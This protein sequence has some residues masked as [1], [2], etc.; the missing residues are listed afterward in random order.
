MR[1]RTGGARAL[2][3][4]APDPAHQNSQRVLRNCT[5]RGRRGGPG[6]PGQAG[7]AMASPGRNHRPVNDLRT[8]RAGTGPSVAQPLRLRPASAARRRVH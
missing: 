6:S 3:R 7:S 2:P 8:A 1:G 4:R 5:R